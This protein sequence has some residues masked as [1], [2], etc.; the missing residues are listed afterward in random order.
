MTHGDGLFPNDPATP[1]KGNNWLREREVAPGCFM[2]YDTREEHRNQLIGSVFT[3]ST[4]R[5]TWESWS[6]Y[7][8]YGKGESKIDAIIQMQNGIR[9][10]EETMRMFDLGYRFRINSKVL[11]WATS[12][13]DAKAQRTDNAVTIVEFN[14]YGGTYPTS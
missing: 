8:D 2:I 9:L 5:D 6:K 10:R 12:L 3:A 1:V 4:N 13:V 11:G 14:K 7:S